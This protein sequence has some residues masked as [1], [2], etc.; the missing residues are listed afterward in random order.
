MTT[1]TARTPPDRA[2]GSG[3]ALL[4]WP[5]AIAIFA[6]DTLTP[7]GGAV[8]VLYGVVVL[9][10]AGVFQRRNLIL[11]AIGCAV[12]TVASYLISHGFAF[13]GSPFLRCFVSLSA[14]AITTWL[15]LRNQAAHADLR[16]SEAR[17]RVIFQTAGVAIWSSD[18]T[19]VRAALDAARARGVTDI[20]RHAEAHPE[21]A[22]E[23]LA[24]VGSV[25]VNDTAVTMVGARDGEELSARFRE[26]MLPESMPPFVGLL[27]ALAEGAPSYEAEM[28]LRTFQGET[29][30]TWM[31]VTFP[32]AGGR[33]DN[34]LLTITDM[35]E[36]RRAEEALIQ[37]RADLAHAS[38]LTT[39]GELT[40][41]IAHE[42]NQPLAA[43]VTNGEASLRW[44]NRPEPELDEVRS[45]LQRVIRDGK[46]ASEVVGRIRALLKKGA[47]QTGPVD[48]VEVIEEAALLVQR[49][50]QAQRVSLT[51]D[52]APGLPPVR[53]D[54][55]QLQQV[56][57]N[58]L[59][60]GVHALE[61]VSDRPRRLAV[62]A[63]PGEDGQVAVTV[64]DNG[65]GI[66]EENMARLFGA[67]FT[68]RDAGMGMGLAICRST[69][70]AH[71]GR[72]WAET[73]A[74]GGARLSFVLPALA[75][76]RA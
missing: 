41:T 27:A 21:F 74:D 7:L 31:S 71:G 26:I 15:S 20:R 60:N 52:L 4:A 33:I 54:R 19:A 32:A 1:E 73:P 14:I 56:V 68:T 62:R 55:I 44:L 22:A 65:V 63:G 6:V 57:I 28:P 34:L 67:F 45:S 35:T 38:R 25:S 16:R 51:L 30:S 49:E 2:G 12:L 61:A 42:V 39:L 24:R 69:L 47:P 17:Y 40:A 18:Y 70:E 11:V 36:R 10:A 66:P 13:S 50:L 23:A 76:A 59:V 3:L 5:F 75:E 64:S 46:R 43:I 9:L 37:T 48:L 8:A 53:G 72:I 29:L 58:L